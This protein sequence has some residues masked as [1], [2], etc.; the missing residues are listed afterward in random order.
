MD[1]IVLFLKKDI[2]P[3]ESQKLRKCKERL[4]GS[5]YLR[6]TSCTNAHFLG[7]TYCVYILKHQSYCWRNYIRESVE[8]TRGVDLCLIEPLLRDTSGRACKRKHRN[9]LKSVT[10]AKDLHQTFTNREE[11]S[12]LFPA[13]NHLLNGIWIL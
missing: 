10:N 8:A 7:H 12:I 6:T 4:L 13:L 9:M 2:L 1:P 3:K 11:S 5:G